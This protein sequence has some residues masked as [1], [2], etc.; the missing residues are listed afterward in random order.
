MQCSANIRLAACPVS[1][2]FLSA[3]SVSRE[4]G[5][6]IAKEPQSPRSIGQGRYR[7]VLAKSGRQR[8]ML[9][10]I[11]KRNRLIEMR[12][13]FRDISSIQQGSAQVIMPKHSR[14]RGALLLGKR[15]E[16]GG[17]IA[18]YIAIECHEVRDED[19]VEDREQQQR[20][21]GRFSERF[22][23]FDQQTCPLYSRFGFRRSISF[24][25][26]ERGD[27]RDLKLDLL[28]TQRGRAGQGR[29]LVKGASELLLRLQPA[30]SAP[31]TAVPLCPTIRWP[32]RS[33]PPG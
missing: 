17:E 32:L 1:R 21:F 8:T 11:V 20:V 22:S 5:L 28:A 6:G 19:A 12:S 4:R 31:A 3:S 14:K 33:C 7:L 27:E 29:D 13:C 24:D 25:M 16:M 30:P 15:Q 10:G 2:A 9:G 26:D 23:L 18:T